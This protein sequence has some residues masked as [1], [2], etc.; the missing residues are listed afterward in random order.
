MAHILMPDL[1]FKP[2]HTAAAIK[3]L[4]EETTHSVKVEPGVLY[5]DL[6]QS[7]LDPNIVHVYAVYRDE[8]ALAFH[9]KQSH[10]GE[11]MKNL[12][13]WFAKPP[14]LR[15]AHSA[16]PG[17]AVWEKLAVAKARALAP[18]KA[19]ARGKKLTKVTAKQTVASRK[20]R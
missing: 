12:S 6:M 19:L 11:L 5:F 7:K 10:Y 17:D 13:Q 20:A 8:A 4:V 15:V 14:N 9:Q 2:E 3:A 1:Y 16:K 18:K